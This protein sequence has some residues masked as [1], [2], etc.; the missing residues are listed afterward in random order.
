MKNQKKV[1]FILIMVF[2]LGF[3]QI[4]HSED[5]EKERVSALLQ[6]WVDQDGKSPGVVLGIV[7]NNGQRVYAHGFASKDGAPV[8]AETVFEIGSITKVFSALLIMEMA[9]R[10]ELDPG[11]PVADYLPA[12]LKLPRF[13]E[14]PILLEHLATHTSALPRVQ[15]NH[16][17]ANILDPYADYT[18]A[19]MM[20]FLAGYELTRRPGAKYDYSNLGY[21]LLGYTLVLVA[22]KDFSALLDERVLR[23]LGLPD[24]MISV[25]EGKKKR[26]ATPYGLFGHPVP[27]WSIPEIPACGA[28]NSTV[29]DLLSFLAFNLGL[30][31][32]ANDAL[33]Q[34][35][36][37]LQQ[38]W[39][40]ADESGSAFDEWIWGHEKIKGRD[41]FWYNGG[42]GG[43]RSYIGFIPELKWGVAVLVNS[44]NVCDELALALAKAKLQ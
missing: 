17:P 8:T 12:G 1:G 15:P 29:P 42:T 2:L 16:F 18:A 31:I 21:G 34:A 27:Y 35:L 4:V 36:I 40:Y 39:S 33:N 13:Q 23:P 10:G 20:E 28:L 44:V 38:P 30:Q 11:K 41:Y 19:K 9:R 5:Q 3:F 24:T 14:Q 7:D 6:K 25:P 22:K 43:F 32:S 37:R 26:R